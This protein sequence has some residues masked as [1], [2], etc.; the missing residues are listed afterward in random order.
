MSKELSVEQNGFILTRQWRDSPNGVELDY[1]LSTPSGPV[2]LVISSQFAIFFIAQEQCSAADNYLRKISGWHRKSL[3]MLDFSGLP[4]SGYYFSSQRKLREAREILI[5][6]GLNPLESDI[7]PQD[8]Y[9]IERFIR[10]SI[11]YLTTEKNNDKN[12]ATVVNPKVSSSDYHPGLRVISLDIETAMQGI[13]L[14]SIG[15]FATDKESTFEKVFMVAD[16][17]VAD[18]VE[19]FRNEKDLITSFLNWLAEYDPDVII[20]WNVINFDVWFLEKVC[21]KHR[22]PFRC[23][24]NNGKAHWRLLDEESERRTV[25]LP[26]RIVLDG[27]E[28]L[29]I[30][31]YS[32]ESFALNNVA[33]EMLSKEKL[34]QGN[35]RGEKI[36]DLFLTNKEALAKYNIV[37]CKLVWDIFERAGL[38]DFSIARSQITGLP[39]DRLGGSVASF[40]FRYLPLLHRYGYVAPNVRIDNDIAPSPG[41]FVMDSRPGIYDN[42]AVL[43]FKSLYPSIIRSFKID[44][45]GMAIALSKDLDQ[46]DMV[47]GFNGGWFAKKPTILPELIAD[48][49]A[50]RDTAKE[51]NDNALSQA[52]KI[53][54]NSFYGVLGDDRMSLFRCALG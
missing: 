2:Q 16:S 21:Q 12:P 11:K 22:I 19:I 3:D 42:I 7:N 31:G 35:S 49:W 50:L 1:W 13:E 14:Y 52:I 46:S 15:I 10:G 43:D 30:A 44:P 29:K 27:I 32:F 24:R 53:I 38:L 34:I 40:D 26:G 5:A 45:M 20:G 41:G 33:K 36:T 47:P 54:M 18:Y 51:K 39:L 37:D 8:R 48:L 25:F 23:G 17:D 9:L 28:V 6:N 4:V